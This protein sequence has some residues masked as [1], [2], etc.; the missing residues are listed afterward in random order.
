ML[1]QPLTVAQFPCLM[2]DDYG[3]AFYVHVHTGLQLYSRWGRWC[4]VRPSFFCTPAGQRS[5]SSA[6]PEAGHRPLSLTEL[7]ST[8]WPALYHC[9][10]A[11]LY[12]CELAN[13]GGP[14]L[15]HRGII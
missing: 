14:E 5:K 8:A 15:S 4:Q 6:S 2:V 13:G 3:V 10:T 1:G 12:Y 11:L 7:F 9:A